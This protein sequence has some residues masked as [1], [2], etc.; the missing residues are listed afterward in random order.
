LKSGNKETNPDVSL[1]GVDENYFTIM[2]DNLV[3][4]RQ[5]SADDIRFKRN[6]VVIGNDIKVKLFP[7][8]NVI[9]KEITIDK[10]RFTVIGLLEAKGAMMGQSQ[11]NRAII[12]VTQ[13]LKYYASWWDESLTIQLRAPSKT[14]I[15]ETMDEAIGIMRSIRNVKP[16][17][18]NDFEIESNE[19]I[20][21]QFGSLTGYL[22]IFGWVTGGISLLAA[23]VGIMNIMLISVKER[24]KE[25]GIRKAVGAKSFNIVIQFLIETVT[26]AQLGGFIGIVLGVVVGNVFGSMMGM[27]LTIPVL[28]IVF[29]VAICTLLGVVFGVYPAF[30]AAKLDPIDALRYE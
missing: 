27:D 7:E 10:Q 15:D 20:G 12:P 28:W 16:W 13:F 18:E 29:S 9:G 4:G 17:E 6:V 22:S 14:Q 23:G 8:G 2:S 26:L 1:M 3:A 19:A 24:T 5:F 25:I 21:D 30:K 11:D